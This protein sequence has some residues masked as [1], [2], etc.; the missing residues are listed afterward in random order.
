[1]DKMGNAKPLKRNKYLKSIS[2]DHHHGLLL[3]WKIREGLKRNVPED[4]IKRYADWFWETHLK[5]HF[6]VEE[7]HIFPILGSSDVLVKRALAEHRRL[8]RLFAQND[9]VWRSLSLIEEELDSHI[10]FEER[11]LFNA[12]QQVAT[13]TQLIAVAEHHRDGPNCEDWQDKFWT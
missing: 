1:M 2:R 5:P 9:E 10:R 11:I 13:I 8:T 12:I 7:K 6:D 3:C 4:R